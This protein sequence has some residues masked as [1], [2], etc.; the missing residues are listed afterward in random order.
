VSGVL[1]PRLVSSPC[2]LPALS[3]AELFPL[4]RELGF[5][6][7]EAFSEW[8]AARHDPAGNA[9]ADRASLADFGLRATSFHLPAI[10]DDAGADAALAAARYAADLGAKIVLFKAAER[11]LFARHGKRLLDAAEELGL[12]VVLQN[13]AGSAITTLADYEEVFSSLGHD[14]RLRA[15]LEV[16]HF[17][18]V[19]IPWRD[20]WDFLEVGH[21][22]RVKI[23]WR[24]G[25]DFLGDR[26]ALIHLNEIRAGQSVLFGTGEVDMAGLLREIKLR[27]YEGDIVVELELADNWT[28][29]A[30][31]LEGLRQALA[32]LE[33]LYQT[34]L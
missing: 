27:R 31:T 19:K 3:G 14:P 34:T 23:P 22:Q 17:Q 30:A 10:R 26:V 28:N 1:L 7:Y 33:S 5:A 15:V 2:C 12:T 11:P 21:F 20:G 25:W 29:P 32:H 8:A 16:G 6:K 9:G 18:R 24:D 13:H 4:Y